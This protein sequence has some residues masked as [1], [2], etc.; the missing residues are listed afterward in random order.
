MGKKGGGGSSSTTTTN[1]PWSVQKPYLGGGSVPNYVQN[2]DGTWSQDGSSLNP[3]I[4]GLA[5]NLY[6]QGGMAPDY[7]SGSSNS[8]IQG[9]ANP[10]AP[11]LA[12]QSDWTQQAL[13][14]QAQRALNGSASVDGAQA[15][16]DAI[17]GGQAL[18]DNQGLN[19]LNSLATQDWNAGN[20]GLQ[21]LN[22]MTEAVNPYSEQLLDRAMGKQ[23][24]MIN[25]QFS[26]AGRYGSGAHENAMA[27]AAENLTNDFY[28]NAYNQ[29]QAA[30]QAASNAYL[31]GLSGQAGAAGNAGTIYNTGI[32]QQVVA[33]QTAQQLA[34]QAYTDAAALSEAGGVQDEYN[35]AVIDADIDRYNYEQQ[36]PLLALQNYN[37]MIQ[38]SYGGTS[39]STASQEKQKSSKLGNVVGGAASGASIGGS[40]GGPWGA[41][42]GGIG[43]GLLGLFS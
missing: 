23:S 7:Y 40:M 32:G 8:Y 29:Q 37:D 14:M 17:T 24:S 28:S 20:T 11:T 39:T 43:G 34:N 38:G 18:Q 31:S 30:A 19:T 16:M 26:Q 2:A 36:Q 25:G 9:I 42:I 27:S 21:A 4:F 10:N 13:Q 35:Q 1:E 33:A 22:G 3:G 41:A 6:N 15:S 12:N 5:W